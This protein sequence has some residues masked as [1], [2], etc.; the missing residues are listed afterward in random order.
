MA[1]HEPW[2]VNDE[3]KRSRVGDGGCAALL[4]RATTPSDYAQRLRL[5]IAWSR[6]ADDCFR[7]PLLVRGRARQQDC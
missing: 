5:P 2:A 7:L 6:L 4:R 3:R 1:R